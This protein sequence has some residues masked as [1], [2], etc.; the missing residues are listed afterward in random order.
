M[1]QADNNRYQN[2]PYRR[3]GNSGIKLPAL[4][5]GMWQNFS[6]L[7]PYSDSKKML[8]KAFD[9]GITHFDL[10]NNY[11]PSPGSAEETM[12]QV[13][14]ESFAPYRDE[15]IISTKAGYWG[16]EGPYG[17]FGSRKNLL[18]SLDRSLKRMNLEYVDIFYSHRYDPET[19]LE[20]TMS[21]L[22]TAVQS[23]KALYVGI[24]NYDDEQT[25]RAYNILKD[26]G[27]PLL[28][29]QMRYNMLCRGPEQ[30]LIPLLNELKVGGIAY[31]PLEQGILTPRYLRGIPDDSRAHLTYGT[32]QEQQVTEERINIV[33]KLN[34][35]AVTRGQNVAQ[36]AI[37]W[38]LRPGA[39]VSCLIG[40]SRMEQLLDN[41]KALDNLDLSEDE[42]KAIDDILNNN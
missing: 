23:G 41:I 38:T 26:M 22:A 42:I 16:W 39:A 8:H 40:I 28:I 13:M 9:L 1:Y 14:S 20:E 15:L 4:S 25:A 19:P 21:A 36:L 3:C 33:K 5:L 12:G 32:L 30:K 29:H 7:K 17:E 18:A 35:L 6:D 31:C 34:D 2:M 11:G 10:A 24:S 27:V 37:A